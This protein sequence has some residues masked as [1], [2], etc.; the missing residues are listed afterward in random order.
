MKHSLF[1]LILC[2]FSLSAEA[3]TTIRA[4]VKAGE[5]ADEWIVSVALDND[6][7]YVAM[8]VDV[9][10]PDSVTGTKVRKS[11][12]MQSQTVLSNRMRNGRLRILAYNMTSKPILGNAGVLYTILV[13]APEWPAD[14]ICHLSNIHLTRP[15]SKDV[16]LPDVEFQ[17]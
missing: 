11:E 17:L 12:R 6:Q 13:K 5:Q 10:L 7:E 3:Q 9:E 14:R 8:Q 16:A 4:T 1:V 2:L 15:G